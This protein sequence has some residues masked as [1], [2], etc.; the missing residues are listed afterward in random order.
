MPQ[1]KDG[2]GLDVS[3]PQGQSIAIATVTGTYSATVISGTSAGT[4]LATASDAGGTFGP[5]A[6]GATVRLSAGLNSCVSYEVGVAPVVGDA[7][8]AKYSLDPTTGAVTGLVGPD[9]ANVVLWGAHQRYFTHLFAGTQLNT[10]PQVYDISGAQGHA[11]I[12]TDSNVTELWANAGFASTLDPTTTAGQRL[13]AL[14]LPALN[15]DY[16]GGESIFIWWLGKASPEAAA[17]NLFGSYDASAT[18]S[19][20]RGRVSPTGKWGAAFYDGPTA[21]FRS[22]GDSTLT[23]FDGTTHSVGVWLNG[24]T[25]LGTTFVDETVQVN[26]ASVASVNTLPS[27]T[28]VAGGFDRLRL[29]AD[30]SA[31]GATDRGLATQTRAFVVLRFAATDTLPTQAQVL[32]AM[33]ALRAAPHL[34]LRQGAL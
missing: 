32:A 31:T 9:G 28:Q 15:W 20:L 2:Q 23:A 21:T 33:R 1:I 8:A 25:R 29:G 30:T 12:G 11:T 3:V 5:Y 4:V 17:T 24:Q 16:A 10:D 34:P 18:Q 13:R 27:A 14:I 22:L 26:A 7:P 19:G 6:S